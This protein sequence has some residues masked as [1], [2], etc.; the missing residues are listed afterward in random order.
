M[1]KYSILLCLALAAL[2]TSAFA[3]KPVEHWLNPKVNRVNAEAP[4]SHF[5]SST[6]GRLSLEGQWR[7]NFVRN[8]NESS[9]PTAWKPAGASL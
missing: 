9:Y 8:H 3:A 1:K 7:F 4:R 5:Q 2:C 6:W